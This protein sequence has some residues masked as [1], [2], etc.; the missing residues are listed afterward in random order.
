MSEVKKYLDFKDQLA[1]LNLKMSEHKNSI[2]AIEAELGPL[3]ESA[4][5]LEIVGDSLA[6]KKNAELRAKK[7]S[8]ENLKAEQEASRKRVRIMNEILPDF[9]EKAKAE[10]SGEWLRKFGAA[11]GPFLKQLRE[12][13]E[14]E[15]K[16]VQFRVEAEAAFHSIGLGHS[17][18][19]L[20]PAFLLKAHGSHPQLL[21][22]EFWAKSLE[23]LDIR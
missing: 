22:F 10:L 9:R 14:T 17:P 16:L 21:E 8:L 3:E 20:L 12:T 7:T 5:R 6:G 15:R 4:I 18:I 19:D 23:R 13:A 11:V 1:S 2:E